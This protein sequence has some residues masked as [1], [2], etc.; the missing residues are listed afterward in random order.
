VRTDGTDLTAATLA[1][2]RTEGVTALVVEET[3]TGAVFHATQ[4][5]LRS[6]GISVPADVSLAVLGRPPGDQPGP[7]ISGFEVPRRAMGQAAVRLLASLLDPGRGDPA[8][9]RL[10]TC[11]PVA[12]ETIAPVA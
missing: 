3:D 2:W 4:R 9:H 6:A 5:A 1:G 11:P 8:A 7:E 10:L 12:G